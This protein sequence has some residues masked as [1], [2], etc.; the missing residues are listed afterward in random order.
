MSPALSTN[1]AAVATHHP[2][3]AA[4]AKEVLVSGGNAVDAAV[5][6]IATLCVVLPGS[7]GLGGYGGSMVIYSAK[8]RKCV[9]IDFDSRAP[10]AYR[11]E[12][13][14]DDYAAKG[15]FGYLAVTVPAIVSGL[16]MA[17]RDF[18]TKTW[19]EVTSRSAHIAENGFPMEAESRKH[20]EKWHAAADAVS[21]RAHF[22][23]NK[24]PQAGE[25][26]I[27]KD[28]AALLRRLGDERPEA[29][30]RGDIPKRIVRQIHDHGGILT[31]ADFESYRP[32]IVEPL[33]IDYRG[34]ELFTPPPPSGGITMLQMLKTLELFDLRTLEH[35]GA[36]YLH[37][38]AE[39]AKLCWA[40]RH[41]A[42]GDPDFVTIPLDELLS[43]KSAAERASQVRR[44]DIQ[45]GVES[46]IDSNPHTSNVSVIDHD[47]NMVSLT[48]TQGYQFGSRV[49][50]EG[51][52]L[53]MGHGMS[54][55]D[56]A[57]NH[58][59][60]PEPGKRMHHN[61]SPTIAL[62]DGKPFAA[63][64]LPGGPKIITITAQLLINLI[65]FHCSA[66]ETVLAPRVHS[67]GGE[68][69][70]VS[71]SLAPGIVRELETMGHQ[72]TLGQSIGGPPNEVGGPANAVVVDQHGRVSAASSAAPQAAVVLDSPHSA[73]G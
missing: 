38:V 58:P 68:P 11:D 31:E 13:F 63:V 64:G 28:L 24:I 9:A 60:R 55:F 53:V 47:G 2:L 8:T 46:L 25:P 30:Y 72:V 56:F 57:P 41:R 40:D 73:R 65:D 69:I 66:A 4:A 71:G 14:A 16:T 67:D 34:Y 50:I 20:L 70:S 44:H 45:S 61:M 51:L 32:R 21:Q 62:R 37:L 36:P 26:W 29:F 10:L 48:A 5:A 43:P 23:E 7:V 1:P 42:L 3:A 12:L 54:R 6:A 33:R 18:G 49:V 19:K 39:V 35:W 17:L 15:S 52:G 59:N 27:Q 22:P